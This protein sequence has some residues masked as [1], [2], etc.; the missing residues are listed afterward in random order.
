MLLFARSCLEE[1]RLK[2][3]PSGASIF[4]TA[5]EQLSQEVAKLP[6][7]DLLV[8]GACPEGLSVPSFAQPQR[9][10]FAGR[11]LHGLLK[12]QERGYQRVVV[13]G[14]D[15]PELS[16]IHLQRA[17]ASLRQGRAVF[18]P[19]THGGAY[20][21]GV[22]AKDWQHLSQV[23]WQTDAVQ[24]QLS[25]LFPDACWLE[26]L[27]ELNHLADVSKLLSRK[28]IGGQLWQL[29]WRCLGTVSFLLPSQKPCRNELALGFH[30]HP[31]HAPPSL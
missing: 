20:L 19:A 16:G 18:G 9:A 8:S 23:T 30:N 31:S 22:G 10:S 28:R 6:D 1:A 3:L 2:G 25:I 15:S 17:F 26:A 5:A 24:E 13:V 27:Q 11:L 29:L 12:A 14:L 21:L 7:T 4:A